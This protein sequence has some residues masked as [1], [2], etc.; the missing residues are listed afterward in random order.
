MLNTTVTQTGV[1]NTSVRLSRYTP[2]T[3]VVVSTTGTYFVDVA[4]DPQSVADADA[5]WVPL[6][7]AGDTT[8]KK[9]EL[10]SPYSRVRV[11]TTAGNATMVV[12]QCTEKSG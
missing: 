10:T 8:T 4:A 9:F 7:A 6:Q 1:G 5:I 2:H 12:L 11:R 3:T